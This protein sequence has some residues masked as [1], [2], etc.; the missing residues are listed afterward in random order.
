MGNG[1]EFPELVDKNTTADINSGIS[2]GFLF[3]HCLHSDLKK[4]ALLYI[5]PEKTAK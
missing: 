3:I 2:R 5:F 4:S 1:W